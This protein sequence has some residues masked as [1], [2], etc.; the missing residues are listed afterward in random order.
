MAIK[1]KISIYWWLKFHA[2]TAKR[3]RAQRTSCWALAKHLILQSIE[4]RDPSLTLRMTPPK[5]VALARQNARSDRVCPSCWASAKHLIFRNVLNMEI[6]RIRSG[7][8]SVTFFVAMTKKV[9]IK[10]EFAVLPP[11]APSRKDSGQALPEGGYTL[12]Q[13]TL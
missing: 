9:T 11:P 10:K 5:C 7:W 13:L 3:Q 12:N 6:L 2:K 1:W 8:R 4:Y